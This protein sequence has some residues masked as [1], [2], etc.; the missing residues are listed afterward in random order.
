MNEVFEQYQFQSSWDEMIDNNGQP[1]EGC[2]DLYKAIL[3]FSKEEFDERCN[4]RDRS[5]M[6]R[7]VTFSLSGKESPFPLDP[8]PR[9]ITGG[10]WDVVERGVSQRVKALEMFLKDVYTDGEIT[11][12]GVIPKSLVYNSGGFKREAYGIVPVNGVRIPV[13]G[14]DI[15]RDDSGELFV[16]EDNVRTPSGASYVLENRRAM[17]RIFPS[18]LAEHNIR[19]VAS[20]PLTLL[21]ALRAQAP[22]SCSGDPVIVVLTPGVFNSAYFEHSFLAR[23]MGVELV[24][25]RDLICRNNKVYMK[26]TEGETR[27]DVVYRRVDD[28]FLDPLAFRPDSLIG[29]AGIL[30]AARAGNVSV[31]SAVGNSIADDKLIYTYVPEMIRY[32]LSEE[33]ILKN[34][35]SFDPQDPLAMEYIEENIE[36]LVI[37]PVDASGGYG[38]VI[39]SN[40]SDEVL[41]DTLE[42]I[43]R[44]RRGFVAQPIVK[45]STAPTKV[46]DVLEPR[47]VDLRPFAV[48]LGSSV[49]V[50]PGGLTRVALSRGS[51]VVNSSQGGGSK[52]T[53]V[54]DTPR[55]PSIWMTPPSDVNALSHD[56]KGFFKRERSTQTFSEMDHFVSVRQ[57]L[58]PQQEIQQQSSLGANPSIDA[59]ASIDC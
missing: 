31:T 56:E 18:L 8:I 15:V 47:H 39:G 25:G 30:N 45:L 14:M 9:V 33:P 59:I 4:E 41:K 51:L 24:E 58:R 38:L 35:P 29:C 48:N 52:D 19:P 3:R 28:D 17:T 23:Q 5:F 50:L 49:A 44:D 32:Y 57:E 40:A 54:V 20:Y 26:T 34:V 16:L 7:G 12:D 6:D 36:N 43:R 10:E 53:W 55:V 37:K 22:P 1:R 27:V 2:E 42:K 11:L 21:S 46:G 13:A